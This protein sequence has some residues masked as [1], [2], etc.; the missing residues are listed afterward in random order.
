[1]IDQSNRAGKL[2]VNG[3]DNRTEPLPPTITKRYKHLNKSRGLSL[4]DRKLHRRTNPVKIPVISQRLSPICLP[5]GKSVYRS[6]IY[7]T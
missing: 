5:K 3:S 6:N 7:Y 2:R 4:N 1:M